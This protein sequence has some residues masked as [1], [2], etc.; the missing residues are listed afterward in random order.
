[1]DPKA[2]LR[3]LLAKRNPIVKLEQQIKQDQPTTITESTGS[4][5]LNPEQ[6]QAVQYAL[7]GES[8]CI[9]GPAGTG[10]TFTIRRVIDALMASPLNRI[11]TSSTH[12]HLP[13]TGAPGIISVSFTNKAVNN[14]KRNLPKELQGNCLT[15]HKLLEYGPEKYL[16]EDGNESQRF[17]PYRN[18]DNP[19]PDGIYT[20]II[21]E[22]TM[23]DV[24]LF[25]E[26]MDALPE[27]I[28]AGLQLILVGD[29][30]QLPPVFGKSIFIHA[31]EKGIKTV[32]LTKVYRQAEESPIL[33][34]AHR[35]LSGQIIPEKELT[36]WSIDK[37]DSGN[38]KVYIQPWKK[39]LPA[40]AAILTIKKVLPGMIDSGIYDPFE[41]II[42]CPF[43]VG[44]GTQAMNES[45]ASHVAKK[46]N[47]PVFEIYTG[48]KKVYMRIGERVLYQKSE[49]TVIDIKTNPSYYGKIPREESV[50][51]DY[52]GHDDSDHDIDVSEERAEKE[53]AQVEKWLDAMSSHVEDNESKSQ[54]ASHIVT[55]KSED[56]GIEYQLKKSGDITALALGYAISVH[57]SQGSEYNKVFFIT[58]KSN[59]IMLYREL[60]YTAITRAKNELHIICEPSMFMKGINTQRVPGKNVQEKIENF[61][62]LQE[63]EAKHGSG[64][65]DQIP[66]QLHRFI[67]EQNEHQ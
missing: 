50:T 29:I 6:H 12:K 51:M 33:S 63:R 53:L 9:T 10:K 39:V 5:E 20:L 18:K 59:N 25:N 14:I 28:H 22:A 43:N 11:L 36:N 58:H 23:V 15:I 21:E 27:S 54:Q 32:E 48:I 52:E 7:S 17:V 26:L 57:K 2:K 13:K 42:L 40:E 4:P 56:T 38:G 46:L 41:D 37:R 3:L 55:V 65:L 67:E 64:N 31:M 44:F 1:M 8:F 30:Q 19:L 34:L 62:K 35:V 45:I 49:A 16:T 24:P 61:K 66:K 47:A 60:I